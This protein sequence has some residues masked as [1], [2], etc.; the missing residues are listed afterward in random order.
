MFKKINYSL[1]SGLLQSPFLFLIVAEGHT[2]LMGKAVDNKVFHGYKV[3]NNLLFH[4]LQFADD[5]IIIGEGNW[6][7]L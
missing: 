4:T 5:T 7:N 6:N 3:G 1:T 2:G